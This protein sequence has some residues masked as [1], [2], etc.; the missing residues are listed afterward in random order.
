MKTR[1]LVATQ[2][3]VRGMSAGN[4]AVGEAEADLQNMRER[5]TVMASE[6]AEEVEAGP[7][8]VL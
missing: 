4:P 1:T 7:E 8:A 2:V 3:E 6:V 5:G